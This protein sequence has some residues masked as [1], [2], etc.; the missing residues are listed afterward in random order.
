[1]Q[2]YQGFVSLEYDTLAQCLRALL[3]HLGTAGNLLNFASDFHL[4]QRLR[5]R[6]AAAAT[7]Q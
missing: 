2:P 1:M 5:D 3:R 4:Q 7:T 6:A